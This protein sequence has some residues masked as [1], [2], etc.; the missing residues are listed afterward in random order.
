MAG[1]TA[2]DYFLSRQRL[3]PLDVIAIVATLVVFTAVS[4]PMG[5]LAGLAIVGVRYVTDEL[6]AVAVGQIVLLGVLP[7]PTLLPLLL[8][9]AAL[10]LFLVS[11]FWETRHRTATITLCTLWLVAL[12]LVLVGLQAWLN[13]IW[14][15][16]S[17]F[18]VV[19]LL[20]AYTIHRYERVMLGLV[21]ETDGEG[22]A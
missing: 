6:V 4:G 13:T 12:G 16:A 5:G 19:V 10:L 17:V 18:V 21:T 7:T 2:E 22:D 15:I 1:A 14:Q 8:T 11:G 20:I 3:T 9:E